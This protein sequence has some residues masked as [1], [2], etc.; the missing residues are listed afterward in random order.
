M[1][2]AKLGAIC[3]FGIVGAC[4][5]DEVCNV[6]ENSGCDDGKSCELVEGGDPAC[7]EPF[8]VSGNVFDID[9][10]AAVDGA[11]V[12]ALDIN[13]SPRS[14]V[15]ITDSN[16]NYE[17][18][19]PARRNA[20][21]TLIDDDIT[22][23][24]DAQGF[25]TFPSGVRAAQP[26]AVETAVLMD[27]KYR[28]MTAQTSVGLYPMPGA[29]T[30]SIAGVAELDAD[31]RFGV[32][33]VAETGGFGRS[34]IADVDGKY[35]IFNLAAATYTV[36]A[37]ARDTNYAPAEVTLSDGQH[38]DQDLSL[39]GDPASAVNG[40]VILTQG[41]PP[42]TSVILAVASTFD[43]D[44]LRGESPP[45]LRVPDPGIAPDV[46]GPWTITGVPAG[47]YV[48]LASFENDGGVRE[49]S[50]SGGTDLVYV[51]VTA[52]VDVPDAGSFKVTEAVPVIGPGATVVET[53]TSAPNLQWEKDPQAASYQVRVVDALG[54]I[55]MDE[56]V[57]DTSPATYSIPYSGTLTPG[58]YYQ[59]RVLSWDEVPP[60]PSTAAIRASTED[61]RGVFVYQP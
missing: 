26:I 30:G 49:L 55:R 43:P 45:G 50:G 38:A 60:L 32:L 6:D 27:G 35:E 29:P 44:A 10:G 53:V 41:A 20:D 11:R 39:S 47:R 19:V 46:S 40:N 1:R 61:L 37:Y 24:V 54:E 57:V 4:G 9:S 12:V 3:V 15:A 36:T 2:L 34:A 7:F 48:V 14:S 5:G 51:D 18:T 25:V 33:V 13:G 17:L 56:F 52:G 8:V 58:M 28:L 21:G 23:R 31:S 59:F 16:G 42:M 22:L